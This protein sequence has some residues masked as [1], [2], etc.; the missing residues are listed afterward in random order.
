[1][2]GFYDPDHAG[3]SA[4]LPGVILRVRE[5]AHLTPFLNKTELPARLKLSFNKTSFNL[6]HIV[7]QHRITIVIIDECKM[8]RNDSFFVRFINN[9]P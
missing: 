4:P 9:K 7:P 2:P 8:E 1:M 3:L 6:S 5:S